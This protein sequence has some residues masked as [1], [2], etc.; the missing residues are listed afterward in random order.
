MCVGPHKKHFWNGAPRLTHVHLV[1]VPVHACTGSHYA[2]S[3]QPDRVPGSQ[4]CVS[5]DLA[6]LP[7]SYDQGAGRA[8]V[9]WGL[10]QGH[11][12]R[13][14]LHEKPG[15]RFLTTVLVALLLTVT[16]LLP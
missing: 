9:P 14:C 11:E 8:P 5:Q 15:D 1:L 12:A 6:G 16:L 10:V 13:P 7:A 4:Q 2:N 3:L